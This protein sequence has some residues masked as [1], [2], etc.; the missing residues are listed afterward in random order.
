M[1]RDGRQQTQLS[2]DYRYYS[3]HSMKEITWQTKLVQI[4][5]HMPTLCVRSVDMQKPL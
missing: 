2:G 5:T 3:T 1:P 4:V